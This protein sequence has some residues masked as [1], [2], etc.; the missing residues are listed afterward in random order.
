MLPVNE[1]KFNNRK[2]CWEQ[3]FLEIFSKNQ[4]DQVNCYENILV[5]GIRREKK[6]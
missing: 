2:H 5:A 6:N 4:V 3:I 1:M